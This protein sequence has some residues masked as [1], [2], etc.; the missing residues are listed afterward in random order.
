ME[1]EIRK[2]EKSS[3]ILDIEKIIE[4]VNI[5]IWNML[6]SELGSLYKLASYLTDLRID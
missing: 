3:K 5:I 4:M 1:K 6:E 2:L